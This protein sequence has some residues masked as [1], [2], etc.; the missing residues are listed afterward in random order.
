MWGR[1]LQ[2]MG[3]GLSGRRLSSLLELSEDTKGGLG[4]HCPQ[5]PKLI[6]GE[7]R[8]HGASQQGSFQKVAACPG[9]VF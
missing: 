8:P 9:L 4:T 7:S 6:G 3:S 5:S 1:R 2:A